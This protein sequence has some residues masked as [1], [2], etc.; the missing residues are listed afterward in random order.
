MNKVVSQLAITDDPGAPGTMVLDNTLILWMSEIG[1]GNDHNRVSEILYPQ[2]PDSL[3]LVTIG[4]CAGAIKS[5]QVVQYPIAANATASTVN[6]P[7]SDLYLTIAKAMGAGSV[8]FPA[9]TGPL[10]EVLS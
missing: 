9:Q 10:T 2:V 6:R 4:K 1:D 7:A 3:P 5:G 8:S